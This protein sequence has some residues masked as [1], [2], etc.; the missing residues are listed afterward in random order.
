MNL[1]KLVDFKE[2]YAI[3]AEC[4]NLK[5]LGELLHK[6]AYTT[7]VTLKLAVLF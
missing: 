1:I 2:V 3:F 7:N 4:V 6:I 5:I